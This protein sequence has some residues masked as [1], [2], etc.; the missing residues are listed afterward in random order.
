MKGTK[1]ENRKRL[2][3]LMGEVLRE[4]QELEDRI[5][6]EG[7]TPTPEEFQQI[8]DLNRRYKNYAA[9]LRVFFSDEEKLP[10]YNYKLH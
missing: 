1:R 3:H 10:E 4:K 8:D 5:F 7:R 9:I 6:R 2:Q